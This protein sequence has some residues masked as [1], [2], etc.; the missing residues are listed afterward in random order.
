LP[1]QRRQRKRTWS[2]GDAVAFGIRRAGDRTRGPQGAAATQAS[3]I[4]ISVAAAAT[5]AFVGRPHALVGPGQDIGTVVPFV[6]VH[7][8]TGG[9]AADIGVCTSDGKGIFH[10]L[11][12]VDGLLRLS[13]AAVG[14]D[15]IA[16]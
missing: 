9:C 8:I 7:G 14:T 11:L 10:L 3:E 5:A 13:L 12:R 4:G 6:C 1:G 2:I 15:L 16:P